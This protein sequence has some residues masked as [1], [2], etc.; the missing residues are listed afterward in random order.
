MHLL[1]I[2]GAA[3]HLLKHP[4]CYFLHSIWL[5]G[6]GASHRVRRGFIGRLG[7]PT[8]EDLAKRPQSCGWYMQ[9]HSKTEQEWQVS[10]QIPNFEC[11]VQ[12]SRAFMRGNDPAGDSVIDTSTSDSTRGG[13]CRNHLLLTK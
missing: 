3:L 6:T 10:T 4:L 11:A 5:F 1:D 2:Q 9:R 13:Y 12:L 8:A 7:T